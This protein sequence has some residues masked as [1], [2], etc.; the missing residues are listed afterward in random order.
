MKN[1]SKSK[2]QQPPPV[3]LPRNMEERHRP[4]VEALHEVPELSD[5]FKKL[6]GLPA[7]DCR[8]EPEAQA[9]FRA[10]E[11]FAIAQVRLQKNPKAQQAWLDLPSLA[12][13]SA[14]SIHVVNALYSGDSVPSEVNRSTLKTAI[15]TAYRILASQHRLAPLGNLLEK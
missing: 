15:K 1:I 3:T 14:L 10:L 12:G 6:S 5:L 7:M 9:L 11:E 2:Q 13:E 8:L 4:Y